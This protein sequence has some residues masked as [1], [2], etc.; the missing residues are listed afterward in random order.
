VKAHTLRREQSIPASIGRVFD[1]F[2][3][4]ENL[5]VLT[6]PWLGFRILTPVPVEMKTGTR[7]DYRIRLALVPVGWTTRISVWDPPRRFVDVQE[8]GP[9][10]LWEHTHRFEPNGNGVRMT[11]EV[12]YALPL[13]VLGSVI[14]AAVVR[15]AL[16]RIFDYRFARVRDRFEEPESETTNDREPSWGY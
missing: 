10:R 2:S 1:F 5:E 7:I 8:R 13:G 14:H 11:D 16:R 12:R 4:A 9:Y 3:K 15:S 6:P